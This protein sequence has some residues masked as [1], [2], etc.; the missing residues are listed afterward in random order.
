MIRPTFFIRRG[1]RL[2]ARLKH[3]FYTWRFADQVDG[4]IVMLWPPLPA[5]WRQFDG[6]DYSPSNIFD[7]REFYG[8]GGGDRLIFLE[9][10]Q[11]FP[12]QRASLRDPEFEAMRP[13][14]FERS[15]FKGKPLQFHEH[16]AAVFSFA[17]EP[18]TREHTHAT[19]RR[20]YDSL[21]HDPSI[22]RAL[23]SARERIGPDGYVGLHV[24]RGDVDEMLR[25]DLPKLASGKLPADRLALLM[26]HYVC[27]TALDEFYHPEIEAAIR[28]GRKIVYFS[29]S[30]E[31]IGRFASAFGKQHFMDATVFKARLPVQKAF[32]DFNL[33]AGASRIVSTGSNYASFAATLANIDL[34]NVA[35]AG[36]LDRLESNLHDVYLKDL[37]IGAEAKNALHAELERQYARRAR[38]RPLEAN[39]ALPPGVFA[40]PEMEERPS[41]LRDESPTLESARGESGGFLGAAGDV[42]RRLF[43]RRAASSPDAR[44]PEPRP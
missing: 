24:R 3:L 11:N 5:F 4:R 35:V 38:M 26:G 42:W 29:D 40:P 7:L 30:P 43:G 14:A 41:V 37:E 17:D 16:N 25:L 32:L 31:T 23:Q 18:R 36:P 19:L 20:L 12:P 1:D 6:D 8:S 22:V 34:I 44:R 21:P 13:H 28:E 39:E 15:Y 9:T 27:R 33:L 2:I 10:S